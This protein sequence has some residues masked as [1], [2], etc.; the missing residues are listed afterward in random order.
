MLAASRCDSAHDLTELFHRA[1]QFLHG[2]AG[3]LHQ[4]GAMPRLGHRLKLFLLTKPLPTYYR[5]CCLCR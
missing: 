5:R 2:S 3:Y 4:L 1:Q